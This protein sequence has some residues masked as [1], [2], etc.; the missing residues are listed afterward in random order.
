[1]RQLC[2]YIYIYIYVCV[3]VCVSDCLRVLFRI[4]G[5]SLLLIRHHSD[6]ENSPETVGIHLPKHE[7]DSFRSILID[8]HYQL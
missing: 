6:G 7:V 3:C 4:Q 5:T 2:L 1:M 8:S